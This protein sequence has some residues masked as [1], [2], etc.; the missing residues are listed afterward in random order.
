MQILCIENTSNFTSTHCQEWFVN[1]CARIEP[2]GN[3]SSKAG[4]KTIV[5]VVI[6]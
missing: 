2:K 1:C 3:G 4:F 5:A 6:L